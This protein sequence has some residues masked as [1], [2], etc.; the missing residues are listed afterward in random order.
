MYA[1]VESLENQVIDMDP[2]DVLTELS[3][4]FAELWQRT[5]GQPEMTACAQLNG[6]LLMFS[7]PSALTDQ[8]SKQ[9]L[10]DEGYMVVIREVSLSLD[11]VYSPLADAIERRLHCYIGAMQVELEPERSAIHIQFHLRDAPGLWRLTQLNTH[12]L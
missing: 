1:H 5:T 3:R 9:A 4:R 11:R 7:L 12:C 8:Q 10:T 2:S 6:D